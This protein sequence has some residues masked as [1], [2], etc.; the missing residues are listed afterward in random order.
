[1][2]D[3]QQE[4]QPVEAAP[5]ERKPAAPRK[6]AEPK[7]M[8]GVEPAQPEPQVQP[9]I[10]NRHDN[11][12]RH[13]VFHCKPTAMKKNISYT[14]LSPELVNV[15]HAHIFHSHDNRGRPNSQTQKMGGHFH[16]VEQYVDK[17]TGEIKAKCGPAM[18]IV[19]NMLS[20]GRTVQSI[21]PVFEL[22]EVVRDGIVQHHKLVDD[23]THEMAYL[24]S[25]TLSGKIIS[26]KLKED[27]T[28]AQAMG[29]I[30]DPASI[31][32]TTPKPLTAADG[33][34]VE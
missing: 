24:G 4:T 20:N 28:Q 3:Q 14:H 6:P 27:K 26:D 25:E 21:Q 5:K 33:Y 16:Y 7:S 13:D 29:A 15:D 17:K 1:M 19:T 10:R 2:D 31:K 8:E 9:Q 34:T 11:S 12:F 22:Q 18:R 30:I 23:H 32:G